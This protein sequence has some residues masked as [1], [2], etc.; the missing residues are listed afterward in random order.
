[1]GFDA[2]SGESEDSYSVLIHKANNIF[3]FK[4]KKKKNIKVGAAL[5]EEQ[6]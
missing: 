4:G 3:F 5:P 6:V 1:M 2:S